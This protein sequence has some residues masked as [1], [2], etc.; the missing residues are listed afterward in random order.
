MTRFWTDKVLG[1][2]SRLW[3]RYSVGL[4]LIVGLLIGAH[5]VHVHSIKQGAQDAALIDVSGRQRMLSQRIAG[6]SSF[7]LDAEERP[8]FEAAILGALNTFEQ[9]HA[10]LLSS[11]A[12]FPRANALYAEGTPHGLDAQSLAFIALARDALAIPADDPSL[13]ELIHRIKAAAYEPLLASLDDAVKAFGHEAEARLDGLQV[14]QNAALVFALMLLAAEVLFIFMPGQMVV[15]K[16]LA[17]VRQH[18]KN[19]EGQNERLRRLSGKLEHAANHDQLTG[20]AN[21]K[22]LY[23]VLDSALAEKPDQDEN[24]C[25]FHV[26]LD[27]FKEVNDTLGHP[28]GDAVLKHVAD[29]MV[30]R[31]RKTDLVARVGGDEFVIVAKLGSKD[32]VTEAEK[33]ANSLIVRIS[34]SIQFDGQTCSVGA[35]IGF[36]IPDA[37]YT[38]AKELI[39][40]ADIALYEAK[41]AGKGIAVQFN[42]H[43][44]AGL[45]LRHSLIQDLERAVRNGEFVPYLQ[46]KVSL[47]TGEITGFEA[48]VRWE[49]PERGVLMPSDFLELA[50]ETGLVE[51]IDRQVS[52]GALDAL[53]SLRKSGWDV[54]SIALNASGVSLRETAYS[55]ILVSA[56]KTRGLEPQDVHIEVVENILISDADDHALKTLTRLTDSGFKIAIDDFGTGYASLAMLSKLE[57]SFLKI[58]KGLIANLEE[59]KTIQIIEAIV[60]LAKGIDLEVIVEGVESPAQFNKLMKLGCDTGQG[61]GIGRPM[62]VTEAIGWLNSY[63]AKPTQARHGQTQ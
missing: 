25:L 50:E 45:E 21:R 19:L 23:D 63:G 24:L 47:Q 62:P 2:P 8:H 58:D 1:D 17:S 7:L 44:R 14:I 4:S 15:N 52:F 56:V 40:N 34:E 16:S 6:L 28:T 12:D 43:M 22:K 27:R 11:A 39:A 46:P 33:M 29:A 13:E 54:P 3:V 60:G 9:S 53:Q 26:D 49:H 57:L 36:V 51:A 48:L 18:A 42:P 38:N 61:Y 41:N 30:S 31:T 59:D 55:E 32:P 35:S 20:L 37:N 10:H 5:F